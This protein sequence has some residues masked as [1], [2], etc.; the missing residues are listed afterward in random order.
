MSTLEGPCIL[1]YTQYDNETEHSHPNKTILGHSLVPILPDCISLT[2]SL[3]AT[4]F[5]RI[6]MS[7]WYG[8]AMTTSYIC[9][10]MLKPSTLST[11]TTGFGLYSGAKPFGPQTQKHLPFSIL[12]AM[13]SV[14]QG[15]HSRQHTCEQLRKMWI[16]GWQ[17]ING[18][19]ERSEK[20]R[21]RSFLK[22][23]YMLFLLLKRPNFGQGIHSMSAH[24]GWRP[25]GWN[26]EV[27]IYD[28][29][30]RQGDLIGPIR[31]MQTLHIVYFLSWAIRQKMDYT[32][33]KT[34]FVS[35]ITSKLCTDP[36]V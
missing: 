36:D 22:K 31:E 28:C 3:A 33:E 16:W 21:Q 4:D 10:E 19:R 32:V 12:R 27:G 24:R 7:R 2:K 23:H 6:W 8:L 1:R 17:E 14:P 9:L 25:F 35:Y 18:G 30:I 11:N 34:N 26:W 5:Q 15:S 29:G 13:L 20:E